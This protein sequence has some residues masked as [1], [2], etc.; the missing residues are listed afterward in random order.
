MTT[1]EA[2][3]ITAAYRERSREVSAAVEV[4]IA[5]AWR[6]FNPTDASA[7]WPA[8]AKVARGLVLR[9]YGVQRALAVAYLRSHASVS[10]VRDLAALAAPTITLDHVDTALRVTGPV[11]FKTAIADGAVP[12]KAAAL[13]LSQL[14]GAASR[15]SQLGGRATIDRTAR[16]SPVIVGYRRE[17]RAHSCY[18][19]AMLASRGAVYK[20]ESS[21]KVRDVRGGGSRRFH[22]H[23][24][25]SAEPLY[26]HEDEP[27]HVAALSDRWAEVTAGKS[28]QDAVNAWRAAYAA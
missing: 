15:L 7:S 19:C 18:F 16:E 8:V 23:C 11:A 1:V 9:G 3:H 20:T 14:T 13:A 6:A 22:D 5:A 17:A 27:A 2:Q 26:G 4:Q 12:D 10:G 24:R 25:C 21:A 28:G